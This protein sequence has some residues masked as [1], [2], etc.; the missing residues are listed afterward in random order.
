[1]VIYCHT[2]NI[3]DF[4]KFRMEIM[5]SLFSVKLFYVIP[6]NLVWNNNNYMLIRNKYVLNV[7]DSK[8][9]SLIQ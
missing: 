5:P 2:C 6:Q 3:N 1:M 9:F 8:I 4:N 7:L